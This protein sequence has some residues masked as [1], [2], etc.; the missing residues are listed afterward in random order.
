[1]VNDVVHALFLP[2]RRTPWPNEAIGVEGARRAGAAWTRLR[3]QPPQDRCP[4]QSRARAFFELALD[5]RLRLLRFR[6]APEFCIGIHK[7]NQRLSKGAEILQTVRKRGRA[8][9]DDVGPSGSALFGRFGSKS[10]RRRLGR[11]GECLPRSCRRKITRYGL[12]HA[13]TAAIISS[14]PTMLST[15]RKL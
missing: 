12:Y 10:R 6:F 7:E 11:H 9:G 5:L 13:A 4:T 2:W 1:M 3:P 15:R 14:M 8:Y